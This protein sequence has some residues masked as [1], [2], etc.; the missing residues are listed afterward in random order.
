M[1]FAFW[2]FWVKIFPDFSLGPK[3]LKTVW[4]KFDLYSF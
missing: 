4:G 2:A 1:A 3:T